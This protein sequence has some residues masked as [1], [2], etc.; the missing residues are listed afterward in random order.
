MVRQT[1]TR[2]QT[3][4]RKAQRLHSENL[5]QKWS[6]LP[7]LICYDGGMDYFSSYAYSMADA[8]LMSRLVTARMRAG[9]GRTLEP[10]EFDLCACELE[11]LVTQADRIAPGSS[12]AEREATRIAIV[13]AAALRIESSRGLSKGLALTREQMD[14][15]AADVAC[16]RKAI[17]AKAAAGESFRERHAR[18]SKETDDNAARLNLGASL[19]EDIPEGGS[20]VKARL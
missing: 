20:R 17:K 7:R 9:H 11:L 10:H 19:E 12:K 5:T 2:G 8:A 18:L 4:S 16:M 15:C 6:W 13:E 14:E 3:P 1:T